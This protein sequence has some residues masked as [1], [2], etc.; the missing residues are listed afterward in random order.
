MESN[1]QNLAD[2]RRALDANQAAIEDSDAFYL[3]DIAFHQVL[4]EVP[5]NPVLPAIHKAYTSWLSPQW[6]QM[7]RQADRNAS[8]FEAHKAI[9]DAIIMR[10]PDAAEQALRQHLHD[11]WAQVR[12]TFN[13]AS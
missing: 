8:N 3:T 11:A 10:D 5:Q 7:P 12:E 13:F 6:S 9:F 4:Y 2:L 1:K